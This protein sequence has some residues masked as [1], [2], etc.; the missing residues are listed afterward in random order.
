VLRLSKASSIPCQNL[1]KIKTKYIIIKKLRIKFNTNKKY[2]GFFQIFKKLFH[3]KIK[4]KKFSENQTKMTIKL[5]I[6][7]KLFKIK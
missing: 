5:K 2:F 1:K 6:F 3:S 7:Y 4:E